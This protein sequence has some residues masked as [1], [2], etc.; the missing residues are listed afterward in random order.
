MWI[1]ITVSHFTDGYMEGE[2]TDPIG[3]ESRQTVFKALFFMSTGQR[4]T[5]G[6]KPQNPLFYVCDCAQVQTHMC[7]MLALQAHATIPRYLG[8]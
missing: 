5:L 7:A 6:G 3:L 1:G 4:T 2:K 8:G